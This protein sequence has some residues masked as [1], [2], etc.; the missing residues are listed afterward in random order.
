MCIRDRGD[1]PRPGT[2]PSVEN[3]D[4]EV[5]DYYHPLISIIRN[6]SMNNAVYNFLMKVLIYGFVLHCYTAFSVIFIYLVNVE[7]DKHD[8]QILYAVGYSIAA[9]V[10]GTYALV[11]PFTLLRLNSL[12][13]RVLRSYEKHDEAL[14]QVDYL[15][16]TLAF[17]LIIA[18]LALT[19]V[20]TAFGLDIEGGQTINVVA[21]LTLVTVIDGFLFEVVAMIIAIFE[22]N[23]GLRIIR[24][25]LQ[26]RGF[27]Y[28]I[29]EKKEIMRR[30]KKK[31]RFMMG[32]STSMDTAKFT[33]L[34]GSTDK[35][36][37]TDLDV[38]DSMID[39]QS[40]DE[41]EIGLTV[42]AAMKRSKKFRQKWKTIKC[43]WSFALR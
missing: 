4:R 11:G 41:D 26:L 38:D 18:N 27:N 40:P 12:G 15:V 1:S 23:M 39:G 28:W 7:F 5:F 6:N 24:C 9:T 20:S 2:D 21:T 32:G 36:T 13:N 43:N 30:E 25:W 31:A 19:G 34:N 16:Y 17:F 22:Y 29:K 10:V 8:F 33:T 14:K 35:G 3:Y 37:T 42:L